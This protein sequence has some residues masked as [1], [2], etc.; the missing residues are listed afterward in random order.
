MTTTTFIIITNND[1]C[2][3]TQNITVTVEPIQ[4][5]SLGGQVVYS[6][7]GI[8]GC[9]V[10]RYKLADNG[11]YHYEAPMVYTDENG[12]YN[13]P[14]TDPGIYILQVIGPN[15]HPEVL[16]TYYEQVH[17]WQ[18][19]TPIPVL[20]GQNLDIVIVMR[21]NNKK[22]NTLISGNIYYD[23]NSK[24]DE[25]IKGISELPAEEIVV[26]LNEVVQ[27]PF[28]AL[29]ENTFYKYKDASISDELG[30]YQFEN[31]D[32]GKYTNYPTL[33]ENPS[34]PTEIYE[35]TLSE[36]NS[37]INNLNFII[38]QAEINITDIEDINKNDEILIYP[39]PT[40]DN[41]KISY[42]STTNGQINIEI[43]NSIGQK[44][45]SEKLNITEGNNLIDLEM[46]SAPG[47]YIVRISSDKKNQSY[48]IIKK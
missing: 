46:P 10:K 29:D 34:I 21:E 5:T 7:G 6:G 37:D 33:I 17:S 40:K 26:L 30:Y 25:I 47:I 32:Y 15:T 28:N 3:N 8:P 9:K 48:K 36:N 16:M 27:N 41:C 45:T 35:F 14:S 42:S 39:N 13:F 19:A 23:E 38:T 1:N 2:S 43:Y 12:Y 31:I 20:S 4:S 18:L 24:S 44:I 11:T 22:S